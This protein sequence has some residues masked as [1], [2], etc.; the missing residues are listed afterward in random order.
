MPVK[1]S[2]TDQF[3]YIG[4]KR[5]N[6]DDFN[7]FKR[8]LENMISSAVGDRDVVVDFSGSTGIASS[9]IGLLVRLINKFKGT[10]RY[11]R[12]VGTEQ[13]TKTL[14]LTNIDKLGNLT[15]YKDQK[16]FVEQV[17]KISDK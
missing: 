16:E 13:I 6:Y 4:Y 2:T 11:L 8:E 12:I 5:E 15:I 1:K 7:H 17:K 9:E 3:I 14:L 10:A